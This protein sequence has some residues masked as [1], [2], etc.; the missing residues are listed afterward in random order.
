MRAIDIDE[1]VAGLRA[2]MPIT[3]VRSY[4]FAGGLAPLATPVR[5]AL[6]S[7]SDVWMNDPCAHRM[8]YLHNERELKVKV[9][10]FIGAS[11]DELSLCDST[12]RGNNL[13]V[14]MIDA[15]VGSN[16]VVDATT[17]PSALGPW[18]LP[19]KRHVEIRRVVSRDRLPVLEDFERLVDEKTVAVSVSHVC[20]LTGFRHDLAHLG[21]LSRSV[22]AHLLVDG[23][24]SVGSLCIDV[25]RWGVDFLSFGSMKWLL[26]PPGTAFLYVRR[27]LAAT[28]HPPHVGPV[29]STIDWSTGVPDLQVAANGTRHELSSS[30]YAGIDAALAGVTLL[31][32]F[33]PQ[34]IE[35]R[36]IELAQALID[37]LLS[38]GV[39]VR[40]PSERSRHGG[41]VAFTHNA[42]DALRAHLRERKVDVWGY[43]AEQ[44]MRADPH[45]YNTCEDIDR[46][47]RGIEEF[48]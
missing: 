8:D 47:L 30:H 39:E 2:A 26:G 24:Q 31:H 27:D 44:R 16:I 34:Q 25:E 4:L 35:G 15:P 19:G 3:S 7:W 21:A 33:S 1:A 10:S 14:Q 36:V 48:G 22:G 23:A 40:T 29:G 42:P 17:Y 28:L 41:V 9:A 18:L 37:G 43:E 46:L 6:D 11:A 32:A 12:S 45:V 13:A 38:L 20:R 5:A